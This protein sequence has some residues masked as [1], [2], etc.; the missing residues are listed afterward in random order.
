LQATNREVYAI[1]TILK[2]DASGSIEYSENFHVT[3]GNDGIFTLIIGKGSYLAGSKSNLFDI[4]WSG[5]AY[6]LNIKI[7]VKPSIGSTL[8]SSWLPDANYVDIGTSQLWTVPYSFYANNSKYSEGASKLLNTLP[9]EMGGTGV[10]NPIGKKITL[11]KSLSV[12]G[13]G[14]FTITTTGASNITFPTTGTM[15]TLEGVEVFTNKTLSSPILTG[16]PTTPTALLTDNS[17]TIANTEF[18]QSSLSNVKSD[19][20]SSTSTALELK[21]DKSNKTIDIVADANSDTKYPTAKAVKSYIDYNISTNATPDATTISKGKIQLTG[22]LGGTASSPIVNTVGGVNSSTISLLPSAINA[23]T[24]SITANTDIL[25]NATSNATPNTLVKRDELGNF[26]ANVITATLS[27]NA[28]TTSRLLNPVSIYGNTFSGTESIT[29]V[30]A[31]NFGGTGNDNGLNTIKLGGNLTTSSDLSIVGTNSTTIRTEGITDVT[32]PLT[33]TLATLSGTESLTNKTI[34]GVKPEALASGFKIA[35]G[36]ATATTLTVIGD[37]TVGGVNTGD[38]LISLTG[39]VSG[40]GTGIINT[41]I[42]SIGGV[43]SNTISAIP[44]AVSLNTSNIESNTQ[45]ITA[46]TAILNNATSAN[47][48]NTLVK[49]DGTTGGFEAGATKVTTLETNGLA[50]LSSAHVNSDL[51]VVGNTNTGTL[52]VTGKTTIASLGGD[53]V[54]LT[55]ANKGLITIGVLDV[56]HGGTGTSTLG[57]FVDLTSDQTI[58]GNKTFTGNTKVST[59]SATTVDVNGNL[60]VAGATNVSTLGTSG[61][62]TLASAQVNSDLVVSGNTKT[63]TLSSTITDAGILTAGTTTLGSATVNGTLGAGATTLNSA[64]V[65]NGLI[66]NGA[67]SLKNTD[68]AGNLACNRYSFS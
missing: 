10:A 34:N 18:V 48:L 12:K 61:L 36:T 16:T 59:L 8:E 7:A 15:A 65:T 63:G 31:P 46:N 30:L 35:G 2:H 47:V 44:G 4:D 58:T 29:T 27:G 49:R 40:S 53:G 43:S 11:E 6:F 5:D 62:A 51:A 52:S 41:T 45:S 39:D 33:G 3:S 24:I 32:F 20:L 17:K 54:V 28:S 25:N 57:N 67:T 14:D 66:V 9:S 64:T 26:S 22:D 68:V 19:V 42:N 56:A 50:T 13:T 38:Q 55:D 23:N 1:V 37:V 21:E 60:S